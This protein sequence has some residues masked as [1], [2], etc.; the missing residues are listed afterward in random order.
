MMNFRQLFKQVDT[1]PR[2]FLL[3]Q[4]YLALV[5]FVSG[6]D[7]AQS[8]QLLDGFS[9]WVAR[10]SPGIGQTSFGWPT[11][12]AARHWPPALEDSRSIADLPPQLDA[13]VNEDLLRLLDGFLGERGYVTPYL[14]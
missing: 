4:S 7:A 3:S 6:C 10:R 8:G 2:M 14:G 11:I 1:H 9:D 13:Q 12:V 5:S